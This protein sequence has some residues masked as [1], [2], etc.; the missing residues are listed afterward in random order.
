MASIENRSHY[1]VSVKHRDDLTRTFTHNAL[2]KADEYCASLTKQGLKPKLSRLD[3]YYAVRDRSTTRPE[4]TLFASSKLEAEAIKQRLESEQKQGLFVN[5]A[6]GLKTSFADLM[7]RYLREEAPRHKS[8]EVIAYKINAILE[9]AGY[10]RQDIVQIVAEHPNPCAKVKTMTFR[11]PNGKRMGEPAETSK[12]IRKGFATILPED[13]EDYID[14]R[15]QSV[16]GATV[17]REF[18]IFSAVCS[19]AINT[20]RIPVAKSPFDGVRRP[21]YFNERDR[22]LKGDEEAR[23]LRAAYDE[24]RARCIEVRLRQLVQSKGEGTH[25]KYGRIRAR[26]LRTEEAEATYEHVPLMET[27][28]HFQLMT[29]ARRGETLSLTWA[30]VDL[31]AQTAFLPDTKNGRARKLPLRRALVHLLQKLPRDGSRVFP[32]GVDG[33]RKAW[34]RMCVQAGFVEADELRIHD[35]RHEAISR[36]AE[37]GSSTPGGFSLVD[38]QH[39]SGHRDVRMLLRYAHLCTQSLAKRLD[40]AFA[41]EEESDVH[42]GRRRLKADAGITLA[43][44]VEASTQVPEVPPALLTGN[45]ANVIAVDFRSRGAA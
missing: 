39:F 5:Y 17:D 9:D 29:A 34:K 15:C 2:K 21:K 32:I 18:D 23:L 45:A 22:R 16:E 19:I 20:W 42:H 10:P 43:E 8:F 26:K 27:F 35:L 3:D 36:V 12:F 7:I 28:V 4:Q 24:D 44:I 37:A 40:A 33:L 30:N 1:Q 14:E 6:K 31:E 13:F 41:S 38:L 25:S 11:K